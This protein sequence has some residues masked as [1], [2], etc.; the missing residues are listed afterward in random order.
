MM[1]DM[2][3]MLMVVMAMIV[4]IGHSDPDGDEMDHVPLQCQ[5]LS[6]KPNKP[7]GS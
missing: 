1:V 2:M 6:T 4:I 5:V 7:L 3:K